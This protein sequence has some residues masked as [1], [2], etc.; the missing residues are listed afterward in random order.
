MNG[1]FWYIMEKISKMTW[2]KQVIRG[3]LL[4][5]IRRDQMD[6]RE[7][8]LLKKIKR[9]TRSQLLVEILVRNE[10]SGVTTWT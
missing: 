6:A 3:E 10:R 5:G 7:R 1:L 2:G 8:P 9:S 4:K